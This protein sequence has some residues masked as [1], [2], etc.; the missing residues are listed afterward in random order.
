MFIYLMASLICSQYIMVQSMRISDDCG[1]LV[2]VIVLL[3]L[4]DDYI[5]IYMKYEFGTLLNV[6]K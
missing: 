1:S 4:L 3:L 6:Q 5:Y 2:K